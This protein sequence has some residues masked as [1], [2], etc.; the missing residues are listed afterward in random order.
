MSNNK[1]LLEKW[2]QDVVL[3]GAQVMS[4][5]RC[6]ICCMVRDCRTS[7]ER[8]LEVINQLRSQFSQ[9]YLIII[10]NDSKDGTKELVC[11]LDQEDDNTYIDSFLT[12]KVTLPKKMKSGVNPSFSEHRVQ[13]MADYRNRYMTILEDQVG[14]DHVDWVMM[15]DPD[16]R[17]ISIDGIKH[18]FGL[19]SMWDV[20]HAN[21]R[22][23]QGWFSD[24]YYDVYAFA[25]YGDYSVCTEQGLLLSMAKMQGVRYS[26]PLML[27]RS[28]F[29][30]LA[31]YRA[32][33]LKGVRYQCKQND[34]KRV[35]VRCEHVPFHDDLRDAG[36]TRQVLNPSMMV[37]YNT[38]TEALWAWCKIIIRKYLLRA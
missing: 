25:E 24:N 17:Q 30:A 12:G 9:S 13:K 10:E 16:V 27:V 21:G 32:E 1:K 26:M 37:I 15:I 23:K 4:K 36:Y 38:R 6:A 2:H 31:I 29:N 3:E 28:G 22:M 33:A 11:Q 34:D 35:E 14:L 18:S 5:T 20:V 8:N 19:E 7:L